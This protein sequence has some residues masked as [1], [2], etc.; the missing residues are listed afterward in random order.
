MIIIDDNF[1]D[2]ECEAEPADDADGDAEDHAP[3]QVR[4][5]T[6]LH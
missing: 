3:I 6:I 4:S 5:I 2:E 1:S